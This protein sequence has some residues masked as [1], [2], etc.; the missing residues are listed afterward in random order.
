[1]IK[2]ISWLAIC[3]C[4]LCVLLVGCGSADESNIAAT[5]EVEGMPLSEYLEKNYPLDSEEVIIQEDFGPSCKTITITDSEDIKALQ[6]SIQFSKW[7]KFEDGG[8]EEPVYYYVIFNDHTTVAMYKGHPQ[9]F[10]GHGMPNE[11]GGIDKA[12]PA[13]DIPEEFLQTT[14]HMVNKYSN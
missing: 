9:G 13:C 2:K 4:L 8:Y 6:E 1:M 14:L 3:G 7:K 5:D 12:V 10:I 11:G